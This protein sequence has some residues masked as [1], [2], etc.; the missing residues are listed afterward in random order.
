MAGAEYTKIETPDERL[1]Q[2]FIRLND[3]M[4]AVVS[5]LAT[6]PTLE[7]VKALIDAQ[8]AASEERTFKRITEVELRMGTWE[9][10]ANRIGT[11]IDDTMRGFTDNLARQSSENTNFN[12][13]MQS[14][15]KEV[16]GVAKN[17]LETANKVAEG[18]MH[19]S[20]IISS[21]G[22][23]QASTKGTLDTHAHEFIQLRSDVRRIEELEMDTEQRVGMMFDK[24][25]TFEPMLKNMATQADFTHR[26][27]RNL[28]VI[29]QGRIERNKRI[30]EYI[31]SIKG[32]TT[33]A[34]PSAPFL[35]GIANALGIQDR[36]QDFL[37]VL[38]QFF[39]HL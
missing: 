22:G 9:E 21:W 15:L 34:V 10:L 19:N 16:M 2:D 1:M 20:S 39:S 32:M 27:V 7:E 35:V 30:L 24:F 4:D 5:G 33:I 11:K 3:K 23:I 38:E 8:V 12:T 26:F 13:L 29:E 37:W 31:K 28:E 17:A 25:N 14:S 36:F 18:V 6:L